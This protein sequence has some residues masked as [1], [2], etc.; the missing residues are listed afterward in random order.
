MKDGIA[1]TDPSY[2]RYYAGLKVLFR[3]KSNGVFSKHSFQ[4]DTGL[5]P[6]IFD[7][8]AFQS[9]PS[10]SIRTAASHARAVSAM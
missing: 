10:R 2:W 1:I 5:I 4:S 7:K 9:T 6:P 3:N 8:I